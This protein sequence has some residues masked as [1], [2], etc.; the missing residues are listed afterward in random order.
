MGL[1][2]RIHTTETFHQGEVLFVQAAN[3]F[4]HAAKL[5]IM[6]LWLELFLGISTKISNKCQLWRFL[7]KYI[8]G[9]KIFAV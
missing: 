6:Q 3:N 5:H 8:Q 2:F 4:F 1:I 7:T 9:E